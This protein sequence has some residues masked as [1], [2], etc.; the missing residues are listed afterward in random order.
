[1]EE[2][3]GYTINDSFDFKPFFR[4]LSYRDFLTSFTLALLVIAIQE[5]LQYYADETWLS[6]I[7]SSLA[8]PVFLLILPINHILYKI[9]HKRSNNFIGRNLH[10]IIFILA[11][12]AV[13]LLYSYFLSGIY[14]S[15]FD[16]EIGTAIFLIVAIV[17]FTMSFETVIAIL[18]RLLNLVRWQ[19]F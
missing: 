9:E 4:V 16:G 14:Q 11:Y 13:D 12:L 17:I 10:D 6:E 8:L 15:R 19:I 5:V 3:R 18:K 1:M 7:Y 2:Q